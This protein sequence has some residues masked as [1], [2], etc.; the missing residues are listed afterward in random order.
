[1]ALARGLP[2]RKESPVLKELNDIRQLIEK[3]VKE[4][5]RVSQWDM[6]TQTEKN[7]KKIAAAVLPEGK[8]TDEDIQL[9]FDE[10]RILDVIGGSANPTF[11][12]NTPNRKGIN[13]GKS[14]LQFI[15]TDDITRMRDDNRSREMTA[16]A[17]VD[18]SSMLPVR[19][20]PKQLA[21]IQRALESI[22]ASTRGDSPSTEGMGLAQLAN[23]GI[24]ANLKADTPEFITAFTQNAADLGRGF[25]RYSRDSIVNQVTEFGHDIPV[26]EGGLDAS[27]NGR[28][29]AMPAN[30]AAREFKGTLG[31]MRLYG[32]SYTNNQK[33][34][35]MAGDAF[36]M[37]A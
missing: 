34:L 12:L 5:G 16:R 37:A 17:F 1:M 19:D 20:S 7:F 26:A 30:K 36:A 23:S 3:D 22:V 14:L 31:L 24:R 6:T 25:D 8:Y 13:A 2:G 15:P 33:Q 29:Q 18:G 11:N 4:Q 21:E 35:R 28:M 9:A 10:L 32:P 27:S